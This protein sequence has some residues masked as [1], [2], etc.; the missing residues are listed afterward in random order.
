MRTGFALLIIA[1]IFFVCTL[2]SL[3]PKSAYAHG[4]GL[5]LTA[6]TSQHLIDVD[7]SDF[8]IYAGESG[9]FDLRLFADEAR[10]KPVDFSQVWVRVVQK[11][12]LPEGDTIFSGWLSKASFGPTGFTIELPDVGEYNLIVR[13]AS[14]DETIASFTL[15]ITAVKSRARAPLDTRT[16]AIGAG[17]GALIPLMVLFGTWRFATRRRP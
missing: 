15:P 12:D 10:T 4:A 14:T 3:T 17:L 11:G 13:Y 7:Y 6:T 5:T 16:L 2:L 1:A 9:R 8:E